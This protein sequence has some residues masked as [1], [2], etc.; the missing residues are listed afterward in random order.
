MVILSIFLLGR[1]T[2]PTVASSTSHGISKYF[3]IGITAAYVVIFLVA[4]FGNSFG[5]FVVLKKSSSKSATNLFIANMAVADL[6]LTFTVMHFTI[7]FFYRHTRWFGGVL[8]TF[9]C[10][11]LFYAIPISIAA[12][13]FTMMFISF[14]RF[15]AIFYPLREKLFRKPKILSA[16]IWVLS[17]VL[18]IPYVFLFQVEYNAAEGTYY[19]SQVWP[20]EDQNDTL[21]ETYRVL[22]T[23]HIVVFI[24]L[25]AL[26]LCVVVINYSLICRKLRLR[27]IPGN[28]SDGNRA[29]VEKSKRK[30]VG[31][32]VT[33]CVVFALCWFPVYVNHY[34]W[35]VRPDQLHLLPV[36]AQVVFIWIAHANSAINPCLYVLLNSEFRK[37]LFATLVCHSEVAPRPLPPQPVPLVVRGRPLQLEQHNRQH[38]EGPVIE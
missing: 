24:T 19:C 17:I 2:T 25:Y 12:T 36:E 13:V 18:M 14:D 11:A 8:G 10:K 20:W 28:V 31:L 26:P 37:M 21:E 7:A 22:K 34:F 9:T 23:F 33:V 6:L 1:N 32:L 30:V 4:L 5:L 27:Q 35:Y 15:Y 3:I 16:I 38:V 29:N